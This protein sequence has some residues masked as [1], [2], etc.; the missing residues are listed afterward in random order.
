[1]K[2]VPRIY[3][4]ILYRGRGNTIV[5]ARVLYNVVVADLTN[6]LDRLYAFRNRIL[7][8][9]FAY[10]SRSLVSPRGRQCQRWNY[11]DIV[12]FH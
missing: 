3:D 5:I 10:F 1:M 11:I 7:S 2:T 8:F 6:R 4:I 12:I 9:R